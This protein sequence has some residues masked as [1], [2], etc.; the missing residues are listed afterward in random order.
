[1]GGAGDRFPVAAVLTED[2]RV[3]ER[4]HQSHDAL[5]PDPS[6]QPAHDAGMGDF[7]EARL[8][9][10]LQNP[11]VGAGGEEVDLFWRDEVRRDHDQC[12]A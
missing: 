9:I 4:L 5:V 8:Y 1:M 11:L 3:Q 10:A 12:P 7:V 2:A 6:P